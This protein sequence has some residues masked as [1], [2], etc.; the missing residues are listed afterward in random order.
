[1]LLPYAPD[2]AG[3]ALDVAAAKGAT[4]A[5]AR[6]V[7]RRSESLIVKN[8]RVEAVS[9][10]HTAGFGVRVLLDGSWG[11]ASSAELSTR[12]AE[13]VATAAVAIARA[14]ARVRARRVALAAGPVVRDTYRTPV[15]R[16]PFAVPLDER[17]ALLLRADEAMRRVPEVAVAASAIGISRETKV[18]A[19]SEGSLIEQEITETGCGIEATAVGGGEVQRRSYPNSVGRHTA[20]AGW[21]VVTELELPAHGE[22][23]AGEAAQLLRAPLLP[24][25]VRTV[26][27]DPTQVALQV[28]ES[29]GHPTE[30]DRVF[31]QEASF[32]GT[33]FL[34]PE[35]L[36]TFRYGSPA[37]TIVADATVP[38]GLGTFG[39]DDEGTPAQ[40]TV[41]ID[42]GRFTGYLSSRDTAAE[43]QERLAG[44]GHPLS[45]GEPRGSNGAARADGWSRIPI[46]RMTNINLEPGEWRLED[47]I[48][49]TPDGLYLET[50]KSWSIDDRR[51]N[52]Q[53]GTEWCRE[54]K[55]GR[56][57]QLYRNATYTGITPQF[58][59]ACDAVCRE[60]RVWGTPN[61][62]KGE[63]MQV[64]HVGHGAAAARFRDV[65]VGVMR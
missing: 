61:C 5:D 55:G 16:D 24:P 65:Q 15:R 40:R 30:L 4:Y 47:L 1:M 37:V 32:A 19:S 20:T 63:P 48:A 8:G 23:V 41:L 29:C 13:E 26:I 50:N 59:G 14:S 62:G 58:W 31:G 54:I 21:E 46:V 34:T 10:A 28:H 35:K 36:G 57:G 39:Y 25:G 43:L 52:F 6:I 2:I 51:L 38:G 56:L 49:D 60:W 27:L 11:F 12:Q 45:A 7:E 18:F 17:I 42:R 33:S 3:R 9:F 44:L 22:R 53:F 64:A